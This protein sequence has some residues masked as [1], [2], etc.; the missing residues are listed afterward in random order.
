MF[1][2]EEQNRARRELVAE[3]T[4]HPGHLQDCYLRYRHG[5]I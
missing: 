3:P 5:I 1:I 4:A 2:Y